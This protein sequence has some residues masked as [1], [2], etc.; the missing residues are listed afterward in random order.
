MRRY[1]S[2]R[3]GSSISLEKLKEL[4]YS[5]YTHFQDSGYFQENLGIDCIDGY[6]PG[7]IGENI[8]N[9]F[10]RKLRKDNIWPIAVKYKEYNEEDI[11]DLI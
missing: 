3:T 1:Y 6:T 7:I 11:F 10:L 2:F 9:Y 4:I 8:S 5:T